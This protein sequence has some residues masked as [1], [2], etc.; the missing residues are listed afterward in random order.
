MLKENRIL[1][2]RESLLTKCFDLR[3]QWNRALS[4][5]LSC[6]HVMSH[7]IT[8]SICA[9]LSMP[10]NVSLPASAS[11]TIN[12][13]L[14][15]TRFNSVSFSILIKKTLPSKSTAH[16]YNKKNCFY[17]L[18]HIDIAE[19]SPARFFALS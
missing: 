1:Y 13:T 9:F 17:F 2:D 5:R 15:S 16:L 8:P 11:M 12:G 10:L 19:M 18:M 14:I 7:F 3:E 4:L 6:L